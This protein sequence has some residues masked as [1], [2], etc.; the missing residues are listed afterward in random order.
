[1]GCI[2]KQKIKKGAGS[3]PSVCN[4]DKGIRQ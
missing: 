1:M 3:A 2:V 4:H